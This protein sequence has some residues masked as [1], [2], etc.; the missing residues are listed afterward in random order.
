MFPR[1]TG[2]KHFRKKLDKR[3]FERNKLESNSDTEL[4]QYESIFTFIESEGKFY[5]LIFLY[6]SQEHE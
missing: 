2:I 4:E 3:R 6:F 1:S 5:L